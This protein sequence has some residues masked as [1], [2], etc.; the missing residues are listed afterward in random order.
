MY[1]KVSADLSF[2]DR[3]KAIVEFW[4]KNDIFEKSIEHRDG[5]ERFT[6]YDGPPT[7]NGKPHIGHVLTRAIKDLIPRYRTMKGYKVLRKAGW[8]T[9]GLPV[10]LEVEKALGIS[11][12]PEIEKFGIEDFIKKCKASVFTYQSEWEEMSDRVGFW[13]D[14]ENPYVTYHNDYIESVWWALRQIWDKGLL[15]KGHKIMPY[16]PRCGTSLSS[17]E[18]AQGYK[19]VKENSL[20]VKFKVLG[21]DNEYILAWTTTPWTLPSNLALCVNP[22]EKYV[23]FTIEGDENNTVYIMAEAL[24]KSVFGEDAKANILNEYTGEELKGTE[25]EP[26]YSFVKPDKKAYYVIADDYVTMEDGTGV[27]HTAPAFGEDDA[28]V[29]KANGLPFINLVDHQGNFVKETGEWAGTFVKDADKLVIRDLKERNLCFA[30]IPFEH[31]YP[32]CW[33]CD[34]PLLYY[35]CDTWF[36]E[37]TK[38]RD[39]LLANNETVNWM[40]DNIKH[41]RFGNFLEN[42]IDWGLSRTRYWGTPLPIW[43]CECGHRH[44]V[45]SIAELKEMGINCPDDIELHKPYVDNIKLRCEKCGGEMKRVPEV[46]DCWFDSG[47][48]PFAQLHYPFENKEAFEQNFPADFISEAIDQTRGWFY[49]L[50]AISTLLFDKS[51]YKNVVVLGHVQDEKGIKMSKHKGN[52]IAPMDIL[53]DQGSDAVRWYFYSNSA[54]WLPNRFSAKNVSEAQRKFLGTLWNTYCFYV[55]YANIDEFDPTKYNLC[56]LNLTVMDKWILSKLNNV[57]KTVDDYLNEYKITEATRAMNEFVDELS[58]WYVRRSRS[59]FWASELTD[60]KVCAYMTLYTVLVEFAKVSAPF[61]PFMTEE[62]YQNLVR[63]VNE[64]ALE[65]IHMCDFP[66]YDEKY[67]FAE[68]EQEMDA[69]RKVVILGRAARNEANIKNRQPLSKLFIQT[70]NKINADYVNIIL[71]ELN[72]KDVE[73]TKDASGFI[74][75]NFKPQMRT[76]GP[77]YGK[78]MR[79]IFDEIAKMDGAEVMETL[80]SDKPICLNV[81]GTDVEVFKDD[82]LIDTQQKDGFVSASDAGF[83]VVLDTNLTDELIEE[84]FVREIISKIQTMRKDSGFEVTD[85]ISV[86]FDG[87]EKIAKI[88]AAN[89]AEIKSQT[90]ADSIDAGDAKDGKNWNVNGEKVDIAIQKA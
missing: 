88:F 2:V 18:V 59:R 47:S 90:L 65:S 77:K 80:N 63:S 79:P 43:E 78:L 1:R 41:G 57:V 84:G 50:M 7:A 40:P 39:R 3:E 27:V 34:T 29:C 25:Y 49:T 66:K 28:R 23:R 51:P 44:V 69:I 73:L 6:F 76:M 58:N 74:S 81:Q 54:P 9:H 71:E 61:I 89:D 56:D 85:R 19:D 68:I 87:S 52:V 5:C 21:K 14:M 46:I 86:V 8:D 75:Y 31:S 35:A 55:L 32:F 17:H 38:V 30:V 42:I 37:M 22:H 15:Y 13:A 11:G 60:D 12:K 82:V 67:N 24:I 4:K 16:C 33:R 64:N 62:I 45:G 53:N 26:L 48:M 10:E 70:D 83:T 36:I 72:I 20:I